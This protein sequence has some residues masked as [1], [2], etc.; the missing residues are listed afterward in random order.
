M[1]GIGAAGAAR[2]QTVPVTIVNNTG[3]TGKMYITVYGQDPA[4]PTSYL[5][6]DATGKTKPLNTQNNTPTDYGFNH[7]EADQGRDCDGLQQADVQRSLA[8]WP[9]IRQQR[10]R[11]CTEPAAVDGRRSS[12]RPSSNSTNSISNCSVKPYQGLPQNLYSQTIHAASLNGKAY[13]FPL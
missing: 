13:T 12:A 3:I 4:N 8:E 5:V 10:C 11:A 7:A 2:A 9:H 6:S 1:A